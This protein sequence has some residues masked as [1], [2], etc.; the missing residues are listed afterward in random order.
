MI[1]AGNAKDLIA[2]VLNQTD[3]YQISTGTIYSV[4]RL[5]SND[6][7]DGYFW[8]SQND[9]YW[10]PN[11]TSPPLA[12]HLEAGQWVYELPASATLNR[13]GNY[14]QYAF[15]DNT[16]EADATTVSGSGEH[17]IRAEDPIVTSDIPTAAQ[18]A[19][20]IWD[21]LRS[22]HSSVG[23]FG[24][25][26]NINSANIV[27]L[28]WEEPLSDHS[29]VVGSVAE[30][31]EDAYGLTIEQAYV[32]AGAVW[33]ELEAN[34]SISGST[35]QTLSDTKE[36][37]LTAHDLIEHQRGTHTYQ[38][39]GERFWVDPDNGDTAL[40]GA[41]GTRDDPFNNVT[42]AVAAVS[43][44]MH[45]VIFLVAGSSGG[46]TTLT[47][48][49]TINKRYTFLRGPG[50]DFKWTRTGNG[51]TITVTADG[52]ELFGFQIDTAAT[53]SGA[54]IAISGA[55]FVKVQK[56]WINQT[57][58]DGISISNSNNTIIKENVFEESGQSGSGHGI[59]I[60]PVGGSSMHSFILRNHISNVQGDGI[61]M[62][63]GIVDDAVIKQNE[64]HG[65]TGYGINLMGGNDVMIVDNRF[66][67]NALGDI[68]DSGINTAKIN[69]SQY[70]VPLDV[71]LYE[72]EPL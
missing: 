48:A 66:A 45:S 5:E 19:D 26:T 16:T 35:G 24:E 44:S 57:R 54:G 72:S 23:T 42:D 30:Q 37:I 41:T 38:S 46:A 3:G 34:H 32:I 18:V 49:V 71:K 62:L 63:S 20:A 64:I 33:D 67:N 4:I 69:N 15:T 14:I 8:H 59:S 21:E 25:Y 22:E 9:G 36:H 1:I 58:G 40:N 56:C 7:Y 53:G 12:S 2:T 43:D 61:R 70:A 31:L 52:V 50:R 17:Y 11:L 65:S 27:D 55:D 28:I 29:G 47:E 68:N 51:D 10:F 6:G 39:S 13:G 60:D